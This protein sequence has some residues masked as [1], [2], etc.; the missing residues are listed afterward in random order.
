MFDVVLP[1]SLSAKKGDS[2]AFFLGI[3]EESPH[4]AIA[5]HT[6]RDWQGLETLNP[7]T[8]TNKEGVRLSPTF[9]GYLLWRGEGLDQLNTDLAGW[10]HGHLPDGSRLTRPS[11]L[12]RGQLCGEVKLT[13][14]LELENIGRANHSGREGF[15][16]DVSCEGSAAARDW[17][18]DSLAPVFLATIRANREALH[19]AALSRIRESFRDGVA[20]LRAD[21]DKRE[22]EAADI[23][24]RIESQPLPTV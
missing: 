6:G 20:G 24:A 9:S 19:R 7:N 12:F 18:R 10:K 3:R 21:A 16:L 2:Q 8:Y 5:G 1:V 17:L 14:S 13:F 4:L 11:P 22:Q 15:G 23:M